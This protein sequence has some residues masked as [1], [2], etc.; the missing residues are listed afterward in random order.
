MCGR[1][2]DNGLGEFVGVVIVMF[3]IKRKSFTHIVVFFVWVIVWL[4]VKSL[5]P[6]DW[7]LVI[8]ALMGGG[9]GIFT[10]GYFS[11]GNAK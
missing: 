10:I 11:T 2:W 3:P 1:N 4:S 6:C 8:G 7:H 9:Y 5:A